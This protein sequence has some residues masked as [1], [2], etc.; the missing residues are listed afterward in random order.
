MENTMTTVLQPLQRP[1][2]KRSSTYFL[3]DNPAYM[4]VKGNHLSHVRIFIRVSQLDRVE[5]QNRTVYFTFKKMEVDKW[6]KHFQ[7]MAE[8]KV[9]HNHEGHYIVEADQNG[10]GNREQKKAFVTPIAKNIELANSELKET[11][12]MYPGKRY[13]KSPSLVKNKRAKK[14]RYTNHVFQR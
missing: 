4:N 9:R 1:P 8:G 5:R 12:K 13:Y 2:G 7:Q 11:E 3:S 14:P 6:R 10:K